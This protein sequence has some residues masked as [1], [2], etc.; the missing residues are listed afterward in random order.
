[1]YAQGGQQQQQQGG[2]GLVNFVYTAQA[3]NQISLYKGQ[4]INVITFGEKG[5]WSNG[6]NI[7]TGKQCHQDT[8]NCYYVELSMWKQFILGITQLSCIH[9]LPYIY[10]Y[11]SYIYNQVLLVSFHL[12]MLAV[13]QQTHYTQHNYQEPII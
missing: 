2:R 13:L 5:Q 9:I 6:T 1:M 7:E 11:I 12:I 4:I 8:Y 3:A 10:T